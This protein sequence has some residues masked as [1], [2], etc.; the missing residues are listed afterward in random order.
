MSET[1]SKEGADG[2]D[3]SSCGSSTCVR[4]CSSGE[5]FDP[6]EDMESSM[7]VMDGR[8]DQGG[9]RKPVKSGK[10]LT[11]N[12]VEGQ[13]EAAVDSGAVPGV[14][15]GEG[16][17]VDYQ[18]SNEE[19]D[20]E[21]VGESIGSEGYLG[22]LKSQS[23]VQPKAEFD[24]KMDE[25]EDKLMCNETLD[26]EDIQEQ[27][28][29]G[30]AGAHSTVLPSTSITGDIKK[31]GGTVPESDSSGVNRDGNA[32]ADPPAE[33]GSSTRKGPVTRARNRRAPLPPPL[34]KRRR[35]QLVPAKSKAPKSE[36]QPGPKKKNK[37]KDQKQKKREDS[38][39]EQEQHG[40]SNRFQFH[41]DWTPPSASAPGA[42]PEPRIF[43]PTKQQKKSP[44]SVSY[45]P[46][47]RPVRQ[48]HVPGMPAYTN[49]PAAAGL[50]SAP[51]R[52]RVQRDL[53]SYTSVVPL[54]PRIIGGL[55][56][57]IER[58]KQCNCKRSHCLKL[59][60][61]CFASSINCAPSCNCVDCANNGDSDEHVKLRTEAI[62][63]TLERNPHA[64]RPRAL[65]IAGAEAAARSMAGGQS[66]GANSPAPGSSTPRRG[67]DVGTPA[68]KA[69][70]GPPGSTGDKSTP[71]HSRQH[72]GTGGP[73]PSSLPYHTRLSSTSGCNCRKSHCL[74]KYCECFHAAV[75]CT[76]AHCRCTDCQ[77]TEGNEAREKLIVKRR[78]NAEAAAAGAALA[79]HHSRMGGGGSGGGAGGGPEGTDLESEFS[80]SDTG[81]GMTGAAGQAAAAVAAGAAAGG[82][83]VTLPPSSYAIPMQLVDGTQVPGLAF[84]TAGRQELMMGGLASAEF[85]VEGGSGKTGGAPGGDD[86]LPDGGG[87][88]RDPTASSS[89]TLRGAGRSSLRASPRRS[90]GGGQSRGGGH[91]Y[92]G[93]KVE[94]GLEKSWRELAEQTE[95]TQ[96]AVRDILDREEVER[97]KKRE[98][99]RKAVVKAEKE[100]GPTDSSSEAAPNVNAAPAALA[101]T[102]NVPSTPNKKASGVAVPISPS[103]RIGTASTPTRKRRLPSAGTSGG[104]RSASHQ[105]MVQHRAK[106]TL[107][108]L[109][110]ELG[111]VIRATQVAEQRTVEDWE[112]LREEDAAGLGSSSATSESEAHSGI[113]EE[114]ADNAADASMGV[115]DDDTLPPCEETLEPPPEE[116]LRSRLTEEAQRE[117]AILAAQEGAMLHELARI[118]REKALAL[119]RAR[120]ERAREAARRERGNREEAMIG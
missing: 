98:D 11:S 80:Q 115:D 40:S 52:L 42:P 104:W 107:E 120:M 110:A 48:Y 50:Y 70:G 92:V 33:K 94:T 113:V 62:R 84:G 4:S 85:D 87:S 53:D 79:Y 27:A 66:G 106:E 116:V 108:G 118:I 19:K 78:K 88:R 44:E 75:Y 101:P 69:G 65:A 14:N 74:K 41:L 39:P 117:F 21:S 31:A 97:R 35:K 99:A 51:I 54:P 46:P 32:Q 2:N 82:V 89:T 15:K 95:A 83:D 55:R 45:V 61:E 71:L 37:K 16:D 22:Y 111:R 119:G 25:G 8:N 91:Y 77:N 112:M 7:E 86:A 1:N 28:M 63:T 93:K 96:D 103:R 100:S 59:Y 81:A 64:F 67:S 90:P 9:E 17:V 5:K 72:P 10:M 3:T 20:H 30:D 24:G 12:N 6:A 29:A 58:T 68:S 105:R 26:D 47:Q 49:P 60:C 18:S 38:A 114:Q 43:E 13:T 57:Q 34:S 23:N 56:D 102:T 73:S 36:P 109:R 76:S